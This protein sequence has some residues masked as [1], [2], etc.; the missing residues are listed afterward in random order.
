MACDMQITE[1]LH[2]RI[3]LHVSKALQQ[4]Y[5]NQ[6]LQTVILRPV[7]ILLWIKGE[8][9]DKRHLTPKMGYLT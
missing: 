7:R 3:Y 6:P 1:R 2:L 5:V 4:Q 8:G 9:E